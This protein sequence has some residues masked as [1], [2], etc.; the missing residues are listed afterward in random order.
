MSVS[1]DFVA[2]QS[3]NMTKIIAYWISIFVQAPL[4]NIYANLIH[5][6]PW[7]FVR[8]ELTLPKEEKIRFELTLPK[9]EKTDGGRLQN[10]ILLNRLN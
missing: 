4:A 6:R 10:S 3:K 5:A 1:K 8:F 9:E 7:I 2:N